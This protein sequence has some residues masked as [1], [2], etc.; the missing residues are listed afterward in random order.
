[1]KTGGFFRKF[2]F[3]PNEQRVIIFLVITLCIGGGI[4]LYYGSIGN[5]A[6]PHFDYTARDREFEE[7]SSLLAEADSISVHQASLQGDPSAS[8]SHREKK[9]APPHGALDLNAATK[10]DLLGLPGI[11]EAMAERI[12]LY[13]REHGSFA[14]NEELLKVKGIGEKKFLK[15]KPFLRQP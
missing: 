1:M 14:T 10:N 13:R 12:M 15:L 4:K 6:P 8:S 2:G 7:K 11:G 5:V 9:K 3:T